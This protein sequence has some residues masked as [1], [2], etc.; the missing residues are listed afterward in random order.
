MEERLK[1]DVV[2]GDGD[3]SWEAEMRRG[4]AVRKLARIREAHD[5]LHRQVDDSPVRPTFGPVLDECIADVS[6]PCTGRRWGQ[7]AI[8]AL[9]KT[10]ATS[11]VAFQGV[12]TTFDG[13]A[14]PPERTLDRRSK[15]K[16]DQLKTVLR[17][18]A[19]IPDLLYLVRVKFDS[20][21]DGVV[22]TERQRRCNLA[23]DAMSTKRDGMARKGKRNYG[24]SSSVCRTFGSS[25]RLCCTSS[26][27][28]F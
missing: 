1:A 2:P 5:E 25:G 23:V 24:L 10:H 3:S 15:P 13:I 18:T 19:G 9:S 27:R 21:E 7:G 6:R 28:L 8:T 22:H 12:R 26:R 16:R 20:D 17:D 4:Q 14:I 11:P